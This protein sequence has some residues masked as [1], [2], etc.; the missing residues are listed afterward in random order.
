MDTTVDAITHSLELPLGV[1]T[2]T[3]S[4]VHMD[5]L[6][7]RITLLCDDVVTSIVKGLDDYQLLVE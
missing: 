7:H 6:Y 4:L 1:T 2:L 5:D 3:Q